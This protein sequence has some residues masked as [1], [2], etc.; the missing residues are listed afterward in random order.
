M[1]RR[2]LLTVL[3]IATMLL[4]LGGWTVAALRSAWP[5]MG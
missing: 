5:P 3:I 4:A 1:K 2:L